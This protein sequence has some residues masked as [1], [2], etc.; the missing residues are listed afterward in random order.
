MDRA[1]IVAVRS[2]EQKSEHTGMKWGM[3]RASW[4][5]PHDSACSTRESPTAERRALHR[6][7][8]AAGLRTHGRTIAEDRWST[9]R[10]FPG[11]RPSALTTVVPDYRCG[12]APELGSSPAP[13]SLLSLR[14]I[15]GTANGGDIGGQ[16]SKC[17]CKCARNRSLAAIDALAACQHPCLAL[18]FPL[19]IEMGELKWE[20]G[21][22]P[23]CPRN[24]K[25]CI[26]RHEA[27]ES[28]E[29]REG[30]AG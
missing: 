24:C 17:Q 22:C 9:G 29:I 18:S 14:V 19:E 21:R 27:T 2:H 30:G 25:R 10:R 6:A 23:G 15:A 1:P 8:V 12:A 3:T 26:Q 28:M 13:D 4:T 5:P 11:L 16:A 7:T 20:P